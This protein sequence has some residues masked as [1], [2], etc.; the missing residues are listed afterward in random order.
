MEKR[1]LSQIVSTVLLMLIFIVAISIISV[2]LS[3]L[4]KAPSNSVVVQSLS[5]YLEIEEESVEISDNMV[6][7]NVRRNPGGGEIIGLKV[8]LEDED[9][10]IQSLDYS[11]GINE[12][13]SKSISLPYKSS[14]IG[15]IEKISIAPL[16]SVN[17][18]ERLGDIADTTILNNLCGNGVIDQGEECDMGAFSGL[19]SCEDYDY[20]GGTL[21]CNSECKKDFGQCLVEPSYCSYKMYWNVGGNVWDSL[22]VSNIPIIQDEVYV[23]AEHLYGIVPRIKDGE[24]ING[25]IPQSI[26]LDAHL[27]ALESNISLWNIPL[28]FDGYGVIDYES[29]YP[30]WNSTGEEYREMSR[31]LVRDQHPSWTTQQIENQ[32]KIDYED[33]A[34]TIMLETIRKTRELRPNM[35]IGYYDY[36]RRYYWDGYDSSRGDL[37]RAQNDQ[38]SWLWEKVDVLLPS[39]YQF[40]PGVDSLP[41]PSGYALYQQNENFIRTNIREAMRISANNGDL[42]VYAYAWYRYHDSNNKTFVDTN[43]QI[44]N[45]LITNPEDL[46]QQLYLPFEEGADGVF[47]WGW[48]HTSGTLIPS[49]AAQLGAYFNET[50]RPLAQDL[51]QD[52]CS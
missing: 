47:V 30:L 38:L 40:Y 3:P 21:T 41:I 2:M 37:L 49:S 24:V 20:L 50:I 6:N 52:F 18:Q 15:R 8:I 43:I 25:G 39:I 13:E 19:N 28:D 32:A 23:F 45:H 36:P 4:L 34:K 9:G 12:L 27:S 16:F 31:E 35:K 1:G 51:N 11:M 42:P 46:R 48:E 22:D 14:S 33:A 44:G 5:V 26:D 29:W 17:G 7:M 10:M